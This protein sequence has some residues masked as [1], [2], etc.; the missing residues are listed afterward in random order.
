VVQGESIELTL[1]DIYCLT[2]LPM[3]GIVGETQPVL[4]RGRKLRG[5]VDTHGTEECRVKDG[6]IPI[7]ELER[8]ETRAIAVVVVRI[9]GTHA[10]HRISGGLMMIVKSVLAGTYYGWAHMLLMSMRRQLS[11]C[12]RSTGET[13]AS[14]LCCMPSSIYIRFLLYAHM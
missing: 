3:F 4:P 8:L 10:P 11:S 12:R 5:F 7:E 2:S 13:F 6:A 1:T 9:V 14:I